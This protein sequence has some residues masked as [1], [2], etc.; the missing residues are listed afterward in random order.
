L[1]GQ[2][3]AIYSTHAAADCRSDY[4]DGAGR[5]LSEG[6]SG[7]G[8]SGAADSSGGT[9]GADRGL[10]GMACRDGSGC[11]SCAS[12]HLKVAAERSTMGRS[13]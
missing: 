5:S 8:I 7:A 13:V 10:S 2:K 6:G 9:H 12:R 1:I 11:W 4:L 3:S